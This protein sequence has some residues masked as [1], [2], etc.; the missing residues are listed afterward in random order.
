[1]MAQQKSGLK[2]LITGCYAPP[3]GGAS[4]HVKRLFDYLVGKGYACHV[5]DVFDESPSEG[6]PGVYRLRSKVRMY[7]RILISKK[8]DIMHINES[9]W[10]HRAMLILLARLKGIKS[11]ITLHSFRDTNESLSRMNRIALRYTLKHVD[12]IISPGRNEMEKVLQWFPDRQGMG[13]ITPFIPPDI[14]GVE[15][16]L[17]E[18]LAAFIERHPVILCAN[19]SNMDFY[20]GEDVYGLDL[21]VELCSQLNHAADVGVI[22]CLTC[23][24]NTDYLDQIRSR[25]TEYGLTDRFLIYTDEVEFWR[26]IAKSTAFIRPTRTDSFGISV[27]EGVFLGKHTIASDVCD[28]PPGSILFRSGDIEDL[29]QKTLNVLNGSAISNTQGVS[30]NQADF[31]RQIDGAPIIESVYYQLMT[32]STGKEGSCDSP[33]PKT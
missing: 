24:N 26:V 6:P 8:Y 13:I 31:N 32:C 2:I 18:P 10:K 1:M 25:I 28:R 27:A 17:P 7:F 16:E 12:Y 11:V 33:E 4:I 29:R 30:G 21:L 3:Y 19:G 9:M 5:F 22:Y 15:A 20:K 14:Q 23:V